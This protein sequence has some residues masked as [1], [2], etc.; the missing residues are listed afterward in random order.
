MRAETKTRDAFLARVEA[1]EF[2]YSIVLHEGRHAID[3]AS[4]DSF[5]VWELEYRA[6]LSQVALSDAPRPALASILND[7]IGG[8]SPHGKANQKIVG[9]LEGWIATHAPEAGGVAHADRLTD[10][11]IRAAFRSFEPLAKP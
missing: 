11:Q 7:V 4:G 8:D 9:A 2:Q 6:K 10:G 1:D 5:D 3:D